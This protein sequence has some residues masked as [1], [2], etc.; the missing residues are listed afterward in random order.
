MKSYE[1]KVFSFADSDELSKSICTYIEN[2]SKESI[3]KHGRFTVAFSGGSLP[4]TVSKYLVQSSNV[5]FT[6]WY[7]FFADERCV[8]HDDSDSNYLLVKQEFLS[9]LRPE[10]C[11]PES[12][13]ISINEDLVNNSEEAADDYEEKL[14]KVFVGKETVR[15]PVFDLLLLGMGPDGHTCSLFPGFPQVQETGSWVTNIDNSP[16]PPPSRITLTL[17]VLNDAHNVAFVN[18]GSQK[19]QII[20][21]I[22]Q[23]KSTAYPAGLVSPQRGNLYWFMDSQSSSLLSPSVI[24]EF[25]NKL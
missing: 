22:L 16:K 7:V 20:K 12:Q 23:D 14:V 6:K 11:V 17:P 1:K 24:S 21:E 4:K 8:K 10:N 18:S 5:D 19:A 25:S 13:V 9:K 15:Y 3:E 2:L